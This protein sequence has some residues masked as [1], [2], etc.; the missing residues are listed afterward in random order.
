M[1]RGGRHF[2]SAA[3]KSAGSRCVSPH[4]LASVSDA[5]AQ[6]EFRERIH[7]LEVFYKRIESVDAPAAGGAPA[8]AAEAE[9]DPE[10]TARMSQCTIE[11][12]QGFFT[13]VN[14]TCMVCET[15]HCRSCKLLK[16]DGHVCDPDVVATVRYINSQTKDCPKC[17][18]ALQKAGGCDQMMCTNPTCLVVFS[19]RTGKE[20]LG[21]IH[22]PHFFNMPSEL[23]QRV[24][25]ERANR[26]IGAGD[27]EARFVMGVGAAALCDPHAENDPMC[28][29]IQ[30]T[31]FRT[32]LVNAIK[33][34][35]SAEEYN[36]L[37]TI[38]STDQIGSLI[39]LVAHFNADEVRNAQEAL[40]KEGGSER[41]TRMYRIEQLLGERVPQLEKI[42][43]GHYNKYLSK[44]YALTIGEAR[45]VSDFKAQL[46]RID[47]IRTK[48]NRRLE[49]VTVFPQALEDMLRVLVTSSPGDRPGVLKNILELNLE[50]GRLL[51]DINHHA[52]SG[53]NITHTYENRSHQ[54]KVCLGCK[55]QVP[56]VGHLEQV[57]CPNPE[58]L[59]IFNWSGV[60]TVYVD[61]RGRM[62]EVPLG[63]VNVTDPKVIHN[64][65]W[66][67][68]SPELQ[69]KAVANTKALVLA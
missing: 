49:I 8:P 41:S 60:R 26:G 53:L 12:C 5:S 61:N 54:P 51:T 14:G 2:W 36:V 3:A 16:L 64:E 30:S 52:Y 68:L 56:R 13:G 48:L 47:T 44:S 15:V 65:Q 9:E 1:P 10:I 29:D 69:R 39:R 59:C 57:M 35:R 58:C 46:M 43:G 27:R 25:D 6:S 63:I 62:P 17:H 23:R 42:A 38:Y 11:G 22:N 18:T 34:M 4:A 24:V 50:T 40:R 19:W 33:E 45:P 31:I 21:I 32:M 28:V 37:K 7:Q 66:Y 67:K 20:E 55:G